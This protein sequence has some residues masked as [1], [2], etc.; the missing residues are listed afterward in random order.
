MVLALI[1][2][3]GREHTLVWQGENN[4]IFITSLTSPHPNLV[5]DLLEKK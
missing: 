3:E 1:S 2:N 4:F 5:M